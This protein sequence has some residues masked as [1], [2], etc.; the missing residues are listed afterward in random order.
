MNPLQHL[1]VSQSAIGILDSGVGGLSILREIQQQLPDESLIYLADSA[2]APYGERS[3]TEIQ[4]RTLA[5]CDWLA[6]KNCKALVVACNTATAHAIQMVR[7]RYPEPLIIIGVEPGIKPAQTLTCTHT[8]GVLATQNTLNSSKFQAL[9]TRLQTQQPTMRFL[10]QAGTGL[11]PLI[12]QGQADSIAAENLLRTYL[13]P[14]LSQGM[15]T[16]VLGCTHYP[17]LIPTIRRIVGPHVALVDTSQAVSK[18]LASE[19]QRH[20]LLNR[21]ISHLNQKI[22]LYATAMPESLSCMARSLLKQNWGAQA[23]SI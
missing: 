10:C 9:M 12:E 7:E 18:H 5:L 14:M 6:R 20:A 19:L 11:V 2:Y 13:I 23:I 1:D 4:N 21:A 15:D 3:I 17:F 22:S 16:L 8:I